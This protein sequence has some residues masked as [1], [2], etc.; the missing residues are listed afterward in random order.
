MNLKISI[1]K[2]LENFIFFSLTHTVH[3]HACGG[4]AAE[5]KNM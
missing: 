3:L 1:S 4:E 5:E 2:I